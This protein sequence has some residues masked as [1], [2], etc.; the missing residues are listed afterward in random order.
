MSRHNFEQSGPQGAP[1]SVDGTGKG[2]TGLEKVSDPEKD[3]N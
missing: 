1:A 3:S 2:V